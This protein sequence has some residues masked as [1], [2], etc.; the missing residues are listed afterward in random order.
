MVFINPYLRPAISGEGYQ[1]ESGRLS[2]R[3]IS[4][5]L[6]VKDAWKKFQQNLLSNG[7]FEKW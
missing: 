7:G 4:L 6:V 5:D 1:Y 3:S 2:G